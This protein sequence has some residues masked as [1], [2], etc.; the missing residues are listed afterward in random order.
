MVNTQ[1]LELFRPFTAVRTLHI[2]HPCQ[3]FIV[4][5]LQELTV[6]MATAVLPALSNIYLETYEPY[7]PEQ[8]Q[9]VMRFI[10]VCQYSGHPVAI[11]PWDL[12]TTH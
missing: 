10:A 1:W 5:A 12:W 9:G 4:S 8:Q 11:Q 3:S 6:E 7:G 2:S